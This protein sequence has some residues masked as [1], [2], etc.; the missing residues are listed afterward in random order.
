MISNQNLTC[1]L[2]SN[3]IEIAKNGH[4]LKR[5][6]WS[7]LFQRYSSRTI[8]RAR[9]YWVLYQINLVTLVTIKFQQK[10]NLALKNQHDPQNN[11]LLSAR[12]WYAKWCLHHVHS[13]LCTVNKFNIQKINIK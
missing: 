7:F 10:T 6:P 3:L 2:S 11:F 4:F 12:I 13:Y 8:Y 1:T 9:K 5:C